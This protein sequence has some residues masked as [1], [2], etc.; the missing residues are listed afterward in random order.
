MRTANLNSMVQVLP[1][2][3]RFQVFEKTLRRGS[4]TALSGSPRES[5]RRYHQRVSL[6]FS[7]KELCEQVFDEIIDT[8]VM[9]VQ[10]QIAESQRIAR[11]YDD[12][13]N[14]EIEVSR[15]QWILRCGR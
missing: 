3:S 15:S 12:E 9:K 10:R 8:I 14:L 11:D 7:R 6:T 4:K 1:S 13:P 2:L 5:Q